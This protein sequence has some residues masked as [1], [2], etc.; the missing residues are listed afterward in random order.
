[1]GKIIATLTKQRAKEIID[2]KV[3][4]KAFTSSTDE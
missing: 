1:M 2:G 3:D 4:A